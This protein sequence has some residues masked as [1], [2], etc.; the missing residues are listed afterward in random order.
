MAKQEE[1]NTLGCWKR[2]CCANKSV[3][4]RGGG[5]REWYSEE[6][7]WYSEEGGGVLRNGGPLPFL[8][9][10]LHLRPDVSDVRAA[11][12]AMATRGYNH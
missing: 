6:Q 11:H 2:N 9:S 3:V 8:P 1:H 7:E 12:A 10:L 5:T 4:F